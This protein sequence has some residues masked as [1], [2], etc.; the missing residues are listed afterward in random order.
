MM[1]RLHYQL[2]P[3]A[4]TK[5][6]RVLQGKIWDVAVDIRK[7][8]PTYLKWLGQELSD[9]NKRQYL[10]PRGFAHGFAVMSESAVVLYQCDEFYAPD[11]EEGIRFDDPTLGVEWKIPPGERI[12]SQKDM[13]LPLLEE[14]RMNF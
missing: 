8:S 5:L 10:I 11:Y 1:Y 4:Q 7:N 6:V 13:G 14:A 3:R 12:I 2:Q 9:D